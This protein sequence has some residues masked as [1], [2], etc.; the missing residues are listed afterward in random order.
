MAVTQWSVVEAQ[1]DPVVGSEQSGARPVLVVSN[2]EFNQVIPHA[3][4]LPLTSTQR[5]LYP[6]EIRLPGGVA[7]QLRDSIVLAHQIRTISQ[8][9]LGRLFGSLEDVA[10]RSQVQQAI[11][12][13]LS[14]P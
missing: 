10:L 8:Q 9:R 11:K 6:S 3:T 5:R 7:G 14:L 13:H 4:V 2:D 1:L 12:E